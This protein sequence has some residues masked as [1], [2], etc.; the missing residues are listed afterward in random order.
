[1]VE[2]EDERL[3]AKSKE[4]KRTVDALLNELVKDYA[5]RKKRSASKLPSHLKWLRKEPG[6]SAPA[7]SPR[8]T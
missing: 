5:A 2:K 6:A 7:V 1:M 3:P 4:R 8:V